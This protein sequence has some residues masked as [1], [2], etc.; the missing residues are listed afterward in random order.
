MKAFKIIVIVFVV[1]VGLVVFGMWQAGVFQKI[2]FK[3][4]EIGPLNM[5][6]AEHKGSYMKITETIAL[7]DKYLKDNKYASIDS[8]GEYLS[9]PSKVKEADL[10]SNGGMLVQK[11]V[12]KL[13]E[14]FK[15]KKIDKRLYVTAVFKGH[16]AMGAFVVYPKAMPWITQNGYTINNGVIEIYKMNGKDWEIEYLFP[17]TK[18]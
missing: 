10:L 8:F 18:K 5:V 16:P 1:L 13:P 14:P 2:E 11:P 4:Q 12:V 3:T 6:Y 7:V 17:V 9:D 15:F